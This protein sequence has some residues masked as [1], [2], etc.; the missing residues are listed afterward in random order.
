MS[1]ARKAKHRTGARLRKVKNAELPV[2]RGILDPR[3]Q[4][5]IEY[6]KA[7]FHRKI[8]LD[9]LADAANLSKY[10]FVHLFTTEIGIP[11]I[12]YLTR[13]R[14][15]EARHLL[16]TTRLSIKEIRAKTGYDTGSNFINLFKGYFDDTPTEYRRKA[17]P[18]RQKI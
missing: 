10:H 2:P 15:N 13:L 18:R 5:A 16:E 17:Q 8:R 6:M 9:D 3:I 7:N 4:N 14:M 12:E 1:I 11:P